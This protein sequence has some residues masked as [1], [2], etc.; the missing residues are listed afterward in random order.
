MYL[1]H[2]RSELLAHIQTSNAQYNCQAFGKKIAYKTNCLG[3]TRTFA[4]PI[5]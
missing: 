1:V 5:V 2:R 3:I 4:D